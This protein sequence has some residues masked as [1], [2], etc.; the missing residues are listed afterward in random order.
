M[1]LKADIRNDSEYKKFKKIVAK[2]QERLHIER[3]QK[4]A[5]AMH[6]GR[7]GRTIY[8][9]KKYSPRALLDACMNDMAC[10]SRL[11]EIRVQ[12]SN[13]IDTLKEAVEAMKR[14]ITTEY[15]EEMKEFKTIKAK[16][17]FMENLMSSA[18]EIESEGSSLIKILDTIIED[19]DKSSY[20]L[21]NMKEAL[22]LL[23]SSKG[24][25]VI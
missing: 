25:K 18:M 2:V 13:Q 14:Y 11:V 19:I 16:N 22:V 7:T 6:A 4:E 17:S 23:D 20:H 15:A 1:G 8:G 5:L 24:G 10:R 9:N 12:C 3:D 21:S